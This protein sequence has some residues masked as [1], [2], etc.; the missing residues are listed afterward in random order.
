MRR[1]MDGV[2]P[3]QVQWRFHKANLSAN[4]NLSLLARDREKLERFIVREPDPIAEY[5][6]VAV[7]R[8][9]FDRYQSDP[10]RHGADAL[11]VYGA[12][13]LAAWLTGRSSGQ[14]A[15]QHCRDSVNICIH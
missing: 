1:A 6:D 8:Q 12:V 9:A 15:P 4:F 5:V 3:P 14:M 13:V 11:T 2:L 7:L 10:A